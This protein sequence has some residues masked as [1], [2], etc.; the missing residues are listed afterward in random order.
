MPLFCFV[1]RSRGE[2]KRKWLGAIWL[3]R[4][5]KLGTGKKILLV[6]FSAFL[7]GG[8]LNF[9]SGFLN[10]FIFFCVA[11][12]R[13]L[14]RARNGIDKL[15]LIS[16]FLFFPFRMYGKSGI[17][18]QR[19]KEKKGTQTQ[20]DLLRDRGRESNK[21]ERTK[22]RI[23]SFIFYLDAFF[24]F[25]DPHFPISLALQLCRFP[26]LLPLVINGRLGKG[27]TQLPISRSSPE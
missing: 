19:K 9:N 4:C 24:P 25:C 7:W 2:R 13:S 11:F 14:A 17:F 8:G 3:M 16:P 27:K 1:F 18:R 15:R 6:F 23:F 5:R 20:I 26:F 12:H 22:D 21:R 10:I